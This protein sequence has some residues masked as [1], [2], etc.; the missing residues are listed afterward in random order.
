[1][2]RR[3]AY[4]LQELH[5]LHANLRLVFILMLLLTLA[6]LGYVGIK[7]AFLQEPM[8]GLEFGSL[9][10]FALVC[11]V[12]CLGQ[13]QCLKRMRHE[14]RE[15]IELMTFVSPLSVAYIDFDNF[16]LVNDT[17][18]HETGNLVLQ[19][20]AQAVRGAARGEDFVG[21]LGGDEFLVVLPQTD[22]AG[23]LIA[24]ERIKKKLD[25]LDLV[26]HNGERV[27]FLSFSI[28]VA[29][30]RSHHTTQPARVPL[31]VEARR[32]VALIFLL[33]ATARIMSVWWFYPLYSEAGSFFLPF[34]YLQ[35]AGY[36]P[37][38]DY[39]LRGVGGMGARLSDPRRPTRL[40]RL[41]TGDHGPAL[42]AGADAARPQGRRARLLD[43]RGGLRHRVR[44]AQLRG[45]LA[46]LP[47]D[48]RGDFPGVL[49]AALGGDCRG[50]G[51]HD[52]GVAD[53]AFARGG[54]GRATLALAAGRAGD[55]PGFRRLFRRALPGHRAPVAGLLRGGYDATAPVA[56]R[57]GAPRGPPRVRLRRP[58]QRGPERRLLRAT[59]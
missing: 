22:T 13:L 30:A 33:F 35:D 8:S 46:G 58:R 1:V 19:R 3:Y 37:F 40:D 45:R 44:S 11:V 17:F 16:K 4:R 54:Q 51:V 42:R 12:L 31:P 59:G 2:S 25:S 28:G 43:L 52:E 9:C 49:P 7:V 29:T 48:G 53:R 38:F 26:S 56:D 57:L 34:A 32:E 6:L 20:V 18:G 10:F 55:F 21:R 41:R 50:G 39:W 23:A 24:A 47:D 27:D 5:A 14:T 36:Y 15:K